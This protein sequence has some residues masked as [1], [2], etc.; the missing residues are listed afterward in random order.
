[1]L[2]LQGFSSSNYYNVVKLVLLEKGVPFEE[3]IVYSGA[4]DGYRPDYLLQS[5]LGK[6]P[7]LQTSH[8]SIS[9]SR[10][11]IDYLERAYPER[12]LYPSE[13]FAIA[14]LLELTQIID[15]YLELTA[16]RLLPNYFSRTAP[17]ESVARDVSSTLA[18][19]VRALQHLASFDGYILGGSTFT[20]ADA[21]AVIHLPLVSQVAR[22]V[23]GIDPLADVPG[24][25]GYLERMQARETVQRIRADQREDMPKFLTHLKAQRA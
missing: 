6:I 14:K 22:N 3:A 17:S 15:L 24:L 18:K 20:A 8:G 12:P 21:A 1:M 2:V 5:P 16:R 25:A 11:I 9:E 4:G 7:C 19:G 13:P 23:L 10:C